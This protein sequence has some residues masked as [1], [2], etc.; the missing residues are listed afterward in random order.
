[1]HAETVTPCFPCKDVL[2]E[3]SVQWNQ[4]ELLLKI[5]T[6]L[7]ITIIRHEFGAVQPY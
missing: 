4:P 3:G 7:E 5:S 1:M 2:R 6:H